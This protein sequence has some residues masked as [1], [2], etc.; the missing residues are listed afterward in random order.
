MKKIHLLPNLTR[1][2]VNIRPPRRE[3]AP[4]PSCPTE[5][6]EVTL[7]NNMRA[8]IDS[9]RMFGNRRV[10]D[11]TLKEL[12][13]QCLPLQ[14]GYPYIDVGFDWEDGPYYLE[15]IIRKLGLTTLKLG[16]VGSGVWQALNMRVGTFSSQLA[17]EVWIC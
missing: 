11:R 2:T 9:L 1:L 3:N 10:A 12:S 8:L 16:L 14:Q 5:E 6:K 7:A 17:E 15:K 4:I 13:I